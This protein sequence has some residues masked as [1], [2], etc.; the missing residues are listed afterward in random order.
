[1]PRTKLPVRTRANSDKHDL[2]ELAVQCTEAEIEFVDNTYA[3]IRGRRA[4]RLREDFCGTAATTCEWIRLRNTNVGVGVDLDGPTLA[5]GKKRHVAKLSDEQKTRITLQQRNVLSPTGP[6]V[7]V[8]MVLAMN[9]SYWIFDTREVLGSYFKAV[10][11]S[12][13]KDGILF[14]DHYGGSDSYLEIK[15]RRRIGGTRRGFTYIWDQASYNPITNKKTNYIH[16]EFKKGPAWKK[17]F[18]YTWRLWSLVEIRELLEEAGFKNVTVYWEGDDGHGGGDGI[19][20]KTTRGEACRCYI[21]Y[22]SAER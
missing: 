2:Y 11:R 22:I 14:L 8:D 18:E 9:F 4:K 20:K 17:A 21:A 6:G 3:K 7:G 16:F 13:A 1:M 15:E 12:L 19:F 5:N 10:H